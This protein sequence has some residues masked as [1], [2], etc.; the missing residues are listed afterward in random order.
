MP[1][2][3]RRRLLVAIGTLRFR[4]H[5]LF[6]DFTS[7]SS[8]DPFAKVNTEDELWVYISA[9]AKL[10]LLGAPCERRHGRTVSERAAERRA[11]PASPQDVQSGGVPG[12]AAAPPFLHGHLFKGA[13]GEDVEKP[14]NPSILVIL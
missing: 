5:F 11:Q 12:Q 2:I 1:G 14:S 13:Q 4:L 3:K 6:Y 8:L 7:F 9:F 10:I